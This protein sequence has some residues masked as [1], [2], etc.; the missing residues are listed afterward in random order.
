MD[1]TWYGH[2]CF[3]LVERGMA[4]I[5]TDPYADTLGYKLPRLRADVVTISH[6]APGHANIDAWPKGTH[7]VRRPGEY[8]I[9]GVFIIG[10]AMHDLEKERSNTVFLFD[11]DGLN[12][13][14]LGD[15]GFVPSQ[16]D[17]DA[18]GAVNVALVPVGGGNALNAA[19][20]AEVVSLIEPDIVIPM[21]FKTPFTKLKLDE[22]DRFLQA[23]GI[24]KIQTMSSLRVSASALPEQTQVV[25]LE[26][27][28]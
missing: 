25:V 21:H 6:D 13:V 28:Q 8:E 26:P 23:M 16:S 27:Q 5:V 17:V 22:P 20:A 15:L 14:H 7:I 24:D 4:A 1:I 10:V 9:G 3:R 18:L 11:F 19:Q 12:I 2:S